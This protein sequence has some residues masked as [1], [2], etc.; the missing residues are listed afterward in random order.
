MCKC[1]N[2]KTVESVLNCKAT[3]ELCESVEKDLLKADGNLK[4]LLDDRSLTDNQQD[5]DRGS[6]EL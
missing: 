4:E 6:V 5:G 1:N 2:K 3:A